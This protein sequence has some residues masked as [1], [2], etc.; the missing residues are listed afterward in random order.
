VVLQL[1]VALLLGHSRD[2]RLF[3]AT[4]YLVGTGHSPYVPLDL[5]AVF[6]H[7]GFKSISVIGYP[8][9]WPLLLG[10]IYRGTY[11]L[12]HDLIVYNL[13]IKLPVIGANIGLAYLVA[14][15]LD[16][17]GAGRDVARRAWVLL[18]LNPFLLYVGAAWGQIDAIVAD[19]ESGNA[20][21]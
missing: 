4:G 15:V 18:L 10:L 19:L 6:H 11:A 3:M 8:P 5:T 1:A 13:A 16:N 12:G 20:T 7:V 2:T 14:A 17:L 9:P 21:F